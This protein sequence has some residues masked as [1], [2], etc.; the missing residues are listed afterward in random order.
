MFR[1]FAKP[2]EEVVAVFDI[3][4]GSIGSALVKMSRHGTPVILYTHREPITFLTIVSSQQL[5]M[6]MLKLLK[7]VVDNLHR[8]GMHKLH[9]M[10]VRMPVNRAFCFFSSP[11]YIS[12]TRVLTVEKEEAFVV[13]SYVIQDLIKKE[14]ERFQKEL[15]EGKYEQVFGKDVRLLEKKII[16][17]RL[18]GYEIHDPLNKKA[19][20]LDVTFFSSF[21]SEMII[22]EVEDVLQTGFHFRRIDYSSY[23]LASWFSVRHMFPHNQDF[24]FLDISGEVSD[25]ML[26]ETG[27]LSETVSFPVGRSSLLRK[28]VED[29]KVKPEVAHSFI[30]LHAKKAVERSFAAKMDALVADFQEIWRQSLIDTLNGLTK[31]HSLPKQVF[32]TVDEDVADI[33]VAATK[34]EMPAELGIPRNMF[35]VMALTSDT[36]KSLAD[37]SPATLR[38][39]FVAIE[40]AFLNKII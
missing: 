25:I 36:L 6:N 18:N 28:T 9:Q 37:Y 32:M 20:Q 8:E 7:T 27:I 11:W 39:P 19:K 17:T 13:T 30:E 2:E 23:A 33:F 1:L 22:K 15:Q 40:S 3:G 34:K 21:V 12:Q 14:E 29:L 31:Y 35:E 38:D 24:I 16:E 4:N 10:G 26:T 5:L